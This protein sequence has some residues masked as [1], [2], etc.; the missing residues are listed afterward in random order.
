MLAADVSSAVPATDTEASTGAESC[1]A[2]V[3]NGAAVVSDGAAV[4]A[5]DTSHGDAASEREPNALDALRYR[6]GASPYEFTTLSG[7]AIASFLPP[8]MK[9]KIRWPT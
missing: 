4:A 6:P 9:N 3:L 5:G 2:V 7:L 1:A 8:W